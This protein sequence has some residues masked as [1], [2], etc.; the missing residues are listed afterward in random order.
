[1]KSSA[2]EGYSS[3]SVFLM[4]ESIERELE[5]LQAA[6]GAEVKTRLKDPSGALTYAEARIGDSIVMLDHGRG[7]KAATPG[8]VYL[9]TDDAKGTYERAVRSGAVSVEVPVDQPYGIRE[10]RVLDPEGNTWWIGQEKARV[11]A[12][13][14]ERRLAEQRKSRM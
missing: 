1:M 6:F 12:R 4:L 14:V 5:F 10:G 11:P 3:V 2:P 7:G 13:E 9:W 8:T